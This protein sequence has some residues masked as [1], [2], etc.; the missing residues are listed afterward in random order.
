M[1]TPKTLKLLALALPIV[2]LATSAFAHRQ[3]ILP[4]TTVLS[5]EDQWISVEA[6]ISNNLYFPN[7]HAIPLAATEAISP[8]GKKLELQNASQGKIRSS[9]ELLL[10]EQGTYRIFSGRGTMM[11]LWEE[12]GERKRKRGTED[13]FAAMDLASMENLSLR[14]FSSRVETIVTCGEPTSVKPSGHG[15][16]FEFIDHPNDLFSGET[17]H[18]RILLNGKPAPD[19]KFTIVKG[20]DRFRDTEGSIEVI[21]DADGMIE[22]DWPEPGRYWI[23]GSAKIEGGELQGVPVERGSSYTLTVEVLPE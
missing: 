10:E 8:S 20:D 1:K 12:N 21:S 3:W 4:S 19:Q 17:T 7:H 23:N 13:E 16:E 5:G 14:D 11:A 22:I 9:F 2:G 18:W 6:A 15:L